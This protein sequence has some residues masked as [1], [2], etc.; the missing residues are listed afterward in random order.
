MAVALILAGGAGERL[1]PV[2]TAQRAKQFVPLTGKMPLI[3][4]TFNRVKGLVDIS[5]IYVLTTIN[6]ESLVRNMLYE[7]NPDNIIVEPA[8]RNTGP[9]LVLGA[10]CIKR[11]LGLD[12]VVVVL[13]SDHFVSDDM[14]FQENLKRAFEF[15]TVKKHIVTIGVKPDRP[16]TEYGYIS[17]GDEL[18]TD[19]FKGIKFHE[20]PS[21]Q[22]AREYI[23]NGGYLWNSG[24]LVFQLRVFI[25]KLKKFS[26]ELYQEYLAIKNA[27]DDNAI[28]DIFKQ[29]P[30][31]SIDY[32]LMEKLPSFA[33]ILSRFEW[34]DLGTWRS[35]ETIHTQDQ[36]GNITVGNSE[37]LDIANCVVY[38]EGISVAAIGVK[39]LVIAATQEGVLICPKNQLR[40][41]KQIVER[42]KN[43]VKPN[44]F[45]E[46]D[47]RGMADTELNPQV[48][49]RIGRAFG[50]LMHAK[51][52]TRALI[53]G[54]IRLSTPVIRRHLIDGLTS[55]GI[56]V[57]DIGTVTTPLFYFGLHHLEVDG[58]IMITGSHNPKDFNGLKMALGKTTIYGDEIQKIRKM[59]DEEPIIE[60]SKK[61]DVTNIDISEDYLN[62]LTNKIQLGTRKL[63]VVVDAGNG[64]AA[65]YVVEFLQRLGVE[66]IP[67]FCEADGNFPNHHPDPVKRENLTYLIDWVQKYEADAG[68]A[69][70]GDADRLGVIDEAGQIIWGDKLMILF[71]REILAKH[72]G[73]TALVEVK[74]SQALI[75]EIVKLG[76][77]PVFYKT[78]HSLIKAKMKE[79]KSLFAGEMSGHMFFADEF[80]GFDDAFYAAGRLLRILSNTNKK[81]S[82]LLSDIPMYYSTDET[83][84]DCPDKEK[85][86]VIVKIRD[87]ALKMYTVETIDG[88]RINYPEGWGLVRASNTQPV[89]VARCESKSS[90]GLQFITRDLKE[91]IIRAGVKDFTWD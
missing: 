52:A 77:H 89:L 26:P 29:L 12:E 45:R 59:I 70:D 38:S 74:C 39:D 9:S 44:I 82:E 51:G 36:L 66:V 54:D 20:K 53:G 84:I 3:Q 48:V 56:D 10:A 14:K 65:L 63:K 72:P 15:A 19:V 62:M 1:W 17:V 73:E 50:R 22:R 78:G 90:T 16:E 40:D 8:R 64:G 67:L 91:R 31:I 24:I 27:K 34:D 7:L 4:E 86:E 30:Q 43:R 23:N 28:K 25:E 80:Y 41:V 68:F 49:I 61:G 58:G 47:I 75:D 21:R 87:E 35:L 85:F 60:I 42:L 57:I 81:L 55:V 88:V 79:I 71:W 6:Q 69:Y 83:R 32:A 18:E 13:P 5:K 76:G 33:V 46:Y 37:I 11:K 2:S